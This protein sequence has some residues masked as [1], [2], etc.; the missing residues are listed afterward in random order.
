MLD[1]ICTGKEKKYGYFYFSCAT[2]WC[3]T[4]FNLW[5]IVVPG[6]WR[7]IV[8]R[9][10][11]SPCHTWLNVM[12]FD[13]ELN[14]SLW[15]CVQCTVSWLKWEMSWFNCTG[16]KVDFFWPNFGFWRSKCWKMVNISFCWRRIVKILSECLK[17]IVEILVFQA[18]ERK[19]SQIFSFIV[20][21]LTNNGFSGFRSRKKSC[22]FGYKV[23]MFQLLA[24]NTIALLIN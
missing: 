23:N 2:K 4:Y 20:K 6:D 7:R 15:A 10:E 13:G 3:Q 21:L 18:M 9:R 16:E 22:N 8:I 14:C 12:N 11:S 17:K 24:Q 1:I 5:E 19:N